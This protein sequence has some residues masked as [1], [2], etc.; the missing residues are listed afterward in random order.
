MLKDSTSLKK[1]LENIASL[2]PL[3]SA[4]L[5]QECLGVIVEDSLN[6]SMRSL[7]GHES[8]DR[9]TAFKS[10]TLEDIKGALKVS[11]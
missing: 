9:S 10:A 1:A 3:I 6:R 2:Q 8:G 5:H 7:V 4:L 11:F